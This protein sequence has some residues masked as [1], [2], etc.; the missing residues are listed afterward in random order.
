MTLGLGICLCSL[1]MLVGSRCEA[2]TTAKRSATQANSDH[3]INVTQTDKL[4]VAAPLISTDRYD[5]TIASNNTLRIQ[6]IMKKAGTQC[7]VYF[8][9]GRYYFNGAAP[10]QTGT[11]ETTQ[12][13]QTFA[14]DGMDA[15]ILVQ[16]SIDVSSTIRITHDRSTVREMQICS[17]DCDPKYQQ[18]WEEHRHQAAIHLDAPADR[19][20]VDPRIDHVNINSSGNNII[21]RDF[22]RPFKVGIKLTGPWLNVYVHTMWMRDVE[23]A[24]YI[25][26]GKRIAGPAKFIDVNVYASSPYYG[27]KLWNTFFKSEGHLM[28]QVE[29]IHCTYIGSQFIYI[30]GAPVAPDTDHNP[31]YNMVIDH[32][33]INNCWQDAGDDPKKSG[34]YMNLPPLDDGTNYTRDIRFTS[35]SCTA[36][37]PGRGAFFYVT[38]CIK[39]LTISENDFLS[40]G[41]DKC[42]YVRANTQ[43]GTS[44]IAVRD[45]KISN[46]YFR[47]F[48]APIT[49]GGDRYDTSRVSDAE[50]GVDDDPYTIE[51][52]AISGNQMM[53]EDAVTTIGLTTCFL[54]K[55]RKVIVNGNSFGNTA[56][57]AL[58]ARNCDEMTVTGNNIGGLDKKSS[59]KGIESIGCRMVNMSGNTIRGLN[60]GI[61]ISDS[62]QVSIGQ[63]V[64][65]ET[66]FGISMLGGSGAT[67]QGNSFNG[68]QTGIGLGSVKNAVVSANQV[69]GAEIPLRMADLERVNVVGNLFNGTGLVK[70]DGSNKELQIHS[71]IGLDDSK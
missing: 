24:I 37:A 12:D 21:M 47:S 19:W 52:V 9:A 4:Y 51:Q 59:G 56:K 43:V 16:K 23:N 31:A 65:D 28:E 46:N 38:G 50:K 54:N 60:T 26:Q 55:C 39:G 58:I 18:D 70:V 57:S 68:C 49:I 34:I 41:I 20:Y 32:N 14:G 22:Y 62:Q 40:G 27:S 44:G 33:Y 42:I 67:I 64:I 13:G 15:T 3:F 36:R 25:N 1:V 11:I 35:N 10:G 17:S 30:D 6:A 5:G 2:A 7:I 63:N 8:P 45:V 53:E 29:I 71:N 61:S 69:D 66:L 48:R